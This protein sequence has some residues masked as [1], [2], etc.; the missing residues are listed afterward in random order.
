MLRYALG[1]VLALLCLPAAADPAAVTRLGAL[2]AGIRQFEAGFH[3][4]LLDESGATLQESDG[5]V[6]VRHPGH[7]RWETTVP[8]EQLVVS[9]GDTVWQYD[10]DLQQAVRRPLDKRADQVPS[11]LLSGDID[12]VSKLCEI[13]AAAPVAG[14]EA[15]ELRSRE[16]GGA[17]RDLSIR[18]RAGALAGL[19]ITDGMGQRTRVTFSNVHVPERVDDAVF[20]FVPPPGVDVVDDE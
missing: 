10:P 18:F 2:L 15:F 13:T 1:A 3:Q 8:A 9:D 5:R 16:E 14:E 17:F 19:D 4:V 11:L 6:L 20:R 12:A 7:F